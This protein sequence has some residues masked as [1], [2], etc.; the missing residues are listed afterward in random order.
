M[1]DIREAP[2]GTGMGITIDPDL[3]DTAPGFD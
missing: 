1:T 3:L 2:R